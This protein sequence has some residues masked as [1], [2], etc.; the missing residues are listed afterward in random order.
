M[1]VLV[2][3]SLHLEL[4]YVMGSTLHILKIGLLNCVADR[5]VADGAGLSG[6]LQNSRILGGGNF[7]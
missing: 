7:R 3:K 1:L 2:T 4:D 5:N 6:S